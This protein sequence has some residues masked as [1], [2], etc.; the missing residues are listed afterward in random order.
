MFPIRADKKILPS[1]FKEYPF[2]TASSA[3]SF[4]KCVKLCWHMSVNRAEL[5]TALQDPG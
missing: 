4:F 2:K 3:A 5:D 1:R